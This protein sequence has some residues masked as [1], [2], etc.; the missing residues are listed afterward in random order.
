MSKD[1]RFHQLGDRFVE[2]VMDAVDALDSEFVDDARFADGVLNIDTSRGTFVLNKQAPKHQLW[3]SSPLSGP[4]HYDIDGDGDAV[5]WRS[6][7]DG[8]LLHE[9]LNRELSEVLQAKID[10]RSGGL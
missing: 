4:H 1:S 3:L 8:H 2:H 9:K 6:D 5:V 10:L 7:R